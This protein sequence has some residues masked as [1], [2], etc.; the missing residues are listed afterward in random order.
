M[1]VSWRSYLEA[2]VLL[3]FGK[4][5]N[6]RPLNFSSP[7]RWASS[8]ILSKLLVSCFWMWQFIFVVTIA[9]LHFSGTKETRETAKTFAT[10]TTLLRTKDPHFAIK[11]PAHCTVFC[12]M[13]DATCTTLTK[14]C[15]YI[16]YKNYTKFNYTA[17]PLY[18]TVDVDQCR[19]TVATPKLWRDTFA[20]CKQTVKP[21][22]FKLHTQELAR[23]FKTQRSLQL[24]KIKL[25]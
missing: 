13:T 4:S 5:F 16:Q 11:A 22:W 3:I 24:I 25:F 12:T 18:A 9:I 15:M 23:K 6:L 2:P 8:R 14:W 21:H 19:C 7:L 1:T 10:P 20:I 17:R